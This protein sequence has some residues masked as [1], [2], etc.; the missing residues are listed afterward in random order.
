M[1]ALL[2]KRLRGPSPH[3]HPLPFLQFQMSYLWLFFI[4]VWYAISAIAWYTYGHFKKKTLFR[5]FFN[6][7]YP[8]HILARS[9]LR[10]LCCGR[11]PG[12]AHVDFIELKENFAETFDAE[13]RDKLSHR[14]PQFNFARYLEHG[15]NIAFTRQLH[16]RMHSWAACLVGLYAILLGRVATGTNDATVALAPVLWAVAAVCVAIHTLLY[17]VSRGLLYGLIA[18]VMDRNV[19]AVVVEEE[20]AGVE[21]ESEAPPAWDAAHLGAPPT[22]LERVR[23]GFSVASFFTHIGEVCFLI[24]ACSIA[25]L[26]I[27]SVYEAFCFKPGPCL[28]APFAIAFLPSTTA[29]LAV[30]AFVIHP[31]CVYNVLVYSTGQH[32]DAELLFIVSEEMIGEERTLN[33]ILTWVDDQ[34]DGDLDRAFRL[35]DKDGDRT[36]SRDELREGFNALGMRCTQTE[37]NGLW[38]RINPDQEGDVDLDEFEAIL[39]EMRATRANEVLA[40]SDRAERKRANG[41]QQQRGG[42]GSGS[43]ELADFSD[44]KESS[45]VFIRLATTPRLRARRESIHEKEESQRAAEQAEVRAEE[46]AVLKREQQQ[47]QRRGSG[48]QL[49]AHVAE[50]W[51][52]EA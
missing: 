31:Q 3:T 11:S 33:A 42:D 1:H 25:F 6:D 18:R 17:F 22:M 47:R 49:S 30:A 39:T 13:I 16:I 35:L 28:G 52:M 12:K 24:E 37:F 34:N 9:F 21:E 40:K 7:D 46:S 19:V 4:G 41:E 38:R 48:A 5:W 8:V 14:T 45:N 51:T 15:I 26:A 36:I 32:I 27:I 43:G 29:L 10:R 23:E 50:E 44:F 20:E 2:L